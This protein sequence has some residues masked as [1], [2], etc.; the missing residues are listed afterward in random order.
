MKPHKSSAP[1]VIDRTYWLNGQP[2]IFLGEQ[3]NPRFGFFREAGDHNTFFGARLSR[4]RRRA[5]K[6]EG[7]AKS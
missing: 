7:R 3:E 4:L 5:P 6:R 1:P 2:G